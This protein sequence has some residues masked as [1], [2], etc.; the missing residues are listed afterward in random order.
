VL[1]VLRFSVA[2]PDADG[3]RREAEAALSVLAGRPGFVRG[4]V[5]RAVDDPG[6]WVLAT[7]WTGVGDY[8]RALGSTQ[9]RVAATALLSRAVDEPGGY[10]TLAST[11]PTGPAGPAG[12]AGP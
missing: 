7:E 11:G 3:F 9:V 5:G 8:R 4:H 2:D 1:S 6:L 12:P 10:E